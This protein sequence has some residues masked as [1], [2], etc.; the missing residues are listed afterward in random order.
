M[1]AGSIGE[2]EGAFSRESIAIAVVDADARLLRVN[3]AFSRMT[4]IVPDSRERGGAMSLQDMLAPTVDATALL[5]LLT[6][7][8]TSS[9][10]IASRS[11]D[12]LRADGRS[13]GQAEVGVID[14]ETADDGRP[15]RTV[16]SF[17]D[18]TQGCGGQVHDDATVRSAETRYKDI[19]EHVA[20]GIYRSSLDGVQ[21]SANPA[22][23]K[24]NG[25]ETEA[26]MLTAANDL[27][28]GWYVD[29]GRR[30]TFKALLARQGYVRD[31]VSEIY[32]HKT[33]ERIWIS[34]NAR[35]VRDP[36]TGQP[37]CY[38]GTVRE[39]TA[40]V[41]LLREKE[42][43]DKI[44]AQAPGCLFQSCFP[45]K[46]RPY[47]SYASAGLM[48]LCGLDPKEM[49]AD[50]RSFERRVHPHDRDGLSDAIAESSRTL[51]PWRHEFRMRRK[52]GIDVWVGGAA[53][54]EKRPD[55]T[56]VWHGFLQ[57][58]T[59]ARQAQARIHDL[60]YY[61]TL[62][63]LPN[64]QMLRD[65]AAQELASSDRSGHYG[66]ALFIDLD[67][68]KLL[69]D[70]HG[71]HVGD[72]LLVEIAGRLSGVVRKTDLVA[73]LGGDE[74]VVLLSQL[75]ADPAAALQ[76]AD[77]VAQKLRESVNRPCLLGE[78]EDGSGETISFQTS[79]SIGVEMFRGRAVD[80]DTIL[81]RAD[82][83][84]YR[85]KSS[86]RNEVC[87]F[88]VPL[89]QETRETASIASQV[90]EAIETG[91]ID[92]YVQPIVGSGG[93][94]LGGEALLRWLHP[95]RGVLAPKELL[96]MAD[97]IGL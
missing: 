14:Q 82:M 26:E 54:P 17:V 7:F 96:T 74:F 80:F 31:F 46:G 86:G 57:D 20:E 75:S 43:L 78:A 59:E 19:Y 8:D 1:T 53:M 62:T 16:L 36:E 18:L 50:M 94:V 84:M 87:H 13:I 2:G 40:T 88:S 28:E 92:L 34:E 24:L 60:A 73:R 23:V 10:V 22:L 38:E 68:F 49:M 63:G 52:D 6:L 64:R 39:V 67:N 71:H 47:V 70:T 41:V 55:G 44:A 76:A 45:A 33:R 91:A 81:K 9:G 83:A 85:A 48:D 79:P 15:S 4:G 21:L 58:V 51:R 29:P 56:I 27:E 42:K 66:A 72:R 93:R 65:R 3:Q 77:G 32:R 61:D 97:R 12:F 5:D 11:I 90:R 35:L 89:E 30:G 37:L 95:E 69:N 25:Y